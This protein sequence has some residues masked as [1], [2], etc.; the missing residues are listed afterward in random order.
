MGIKVEFNPDL[1]LRSMDE[2]KAGRR[3]IE[4][5]IPEPLEAGK[6]YSFLKLDQRCYWFMG[7]IALLE[8]K[9]GEQLS[10]PLASIMML[11]ATHSLED[12]QMM[13]RGK[14]KVIEVFSDN[15]IH[16]DWLNRTQND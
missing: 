13:T 10:C 14:Y 5:C 8:T 4:E 6:T 15:K 1:A 11:E 7:E 12:G 3:Q 16:F 9:G 2:F